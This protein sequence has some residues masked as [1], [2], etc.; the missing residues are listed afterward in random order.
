MFAD[1][2]LR[3]PLLSGLH[4]IL[5]APAQTYTHNIFPGES[6][7]F[8]V[9]MN[10]NSNDSVYVPTIT[11]TLGVTAEVES[12]LMYYYLYN[13]G[14]SPTGQANIKWWAYRPLP[15][16]FWAGDPLFPC[17][18]IGTAG[19]PGVFR[20]VVEERMG[21]VRTEMTP[22]VSSNTT[23]AARYWVISVTLP[24]SFTP[25]D[26]TITVSFQGEQVIV[27][28][29]VGTHVVDYGFPISGAMHDAMIDPLAKAGY[30]ITT[31]AQLVD[32]TNTL[33][34]AWGKHGIGNYYEKQHP[35]SIN[36]IYEH[37]LS[38]NGSTDP[39]SPRHYWSDGDAEVKIPQVSIDYFRS[40]IG[41]H[42]YVAFAHMSVRHWG[43]RHKDTFEYP[44]AS[45]AFGRV[46]PVNDWIACESI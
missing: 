19:T 15:P 10:L 28:V 27:P 7:S 37:S 36:S 24:T 3:K 45:T 5:S 46:V 40:L 38:L 35:Y 22:H 13:E 11:H 8:L 30:A 25:G 42:R 12:H 9:Y 18:D 41:K 17:K 39:A 6:V 20:A 23:G 14:K 2:I 29:H 43:P 16:P 44:N 4:Q 21:E 32:F 26:H 33:N 34:A 31:N 1:S